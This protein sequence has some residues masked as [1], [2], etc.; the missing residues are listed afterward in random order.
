MHP[1]IRY[2]L[3]IVIT[4]LLLQTGQGFMYNENASLAWQYGLALVLWVVGGPLVYRY[5]NE[6]VRTVLRNV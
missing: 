3:S 5:T 2:V 4:V 1:Y 6:A